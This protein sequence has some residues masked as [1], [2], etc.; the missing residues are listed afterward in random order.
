MAKIIIQC[1]KGEGCLVYLG[2]WGTD[3]WLASDD[4][5]T[6]ET[7]GPLGDRVDIAYV[8]D[9]IAIHF[10]DEEGTFRVTDKSGRTCRSRMCTAQRLPDRTIFTGCDE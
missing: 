6:V 9:G 7:W 2:P 1:F 3:Y 10:H 5:F 8:G 4:A